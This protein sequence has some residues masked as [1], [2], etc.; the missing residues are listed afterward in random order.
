MMAP[1]VVPLAM[2]T[3]CTASWGTD[4]ADAVFWEDSL[5]VM[6]D[7]SL[8]HILL[9]LLLSIFLF[10][11]VV[12]SAVLGA[13][14]MVALVVA[15]GAVGAM[16]VVAMF[17]TSG[18]RANRADAVVRNNSLGVHWLTLFFVVFVAMT[19]LRPAGLMGTVAAV[20]SLR[21]PAV[22]TARWLRLA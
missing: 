5:S 3:V 10:V 7:C 2:V 16:T 22:V 14:A 8:V 19:T 21:V 18:L 1:L 4:G 9:L 12:G 13:A 11:V 6:E 20:T 15:F 17:A